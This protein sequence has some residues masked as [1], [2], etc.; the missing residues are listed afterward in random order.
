MLTVLAFIAYP[1]II[2]AGALLAMWLTGGVAG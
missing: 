1:I 2:L